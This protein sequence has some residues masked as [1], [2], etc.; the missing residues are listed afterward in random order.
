[1][2]K[3]DYEFVYTFSVFDET[4]NK[5]NKRYQYNKSRTFNK[6]NVK[7]AMTLKTAS[8]KVFHKIAEVADSL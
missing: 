7:N 5:C 2:L 8:K 6:I 1:M 4:D 3:K